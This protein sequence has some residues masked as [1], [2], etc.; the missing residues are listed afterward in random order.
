MLSL[1]S[2]HSKECGKVT[3]SNETR[4]AKFVAA[5]EVLSWSWVSTV[6][7]AE[8]LEVRKSPG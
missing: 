8:A 4:A 5:L 2:V 6:T 3:F 7:A 1:H